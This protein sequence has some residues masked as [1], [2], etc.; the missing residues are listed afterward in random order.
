MT[1]IEKL[2]DVMAQLRDPETGC[3]WDK[4][5][6]Y[7]TIVPHTIEEAYEV[8]EAV[9]LEDYEELKAELGDLLFQVVFYAQIAKEEG[10][11]TFHD[12]A[13]GIADK[14]VRRHPHVFDDHKV[15]DVQEQ[16]RLWDEIKRNEKSD[17]NPQQFVSVLDGVNTL[18]PAVAVARKLQTKAARVGF[19]WPDHLG[20]LH[21]IDEEI[22]EVKEAIDSGCHDKITDEVGDVLFAAVN[23]ARKLG[24]DPE[25]ALRSTNRKFDQ[26]FKAMEQLARDQQ[27]E[28]SKLT[29]EEQE[30]LWVKVKQQNR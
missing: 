19:D 16:K 24:V 21:K 18:Q 22:E 5:Q 2:L 12:V 3:V 27:S 20:T 29:L 9:E 4:Q 26:R 1:P 13:Q 10:R 14:M 17:K 30:V 25:A 15:E 28:F 23:L 8:A 6:T 11:F 7:K